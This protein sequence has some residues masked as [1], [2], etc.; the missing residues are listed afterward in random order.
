[1]IKLI[2]LLNEINGYN[3]QR[4]YRGNDLMMYSQA[5]IERTFPKLTIANLNAL[6]QKMIRSIKFYQKH[7]HDKRYPN[8]SD[9]FDVPGLTKS[10]IKIDRELARRKKYISKPI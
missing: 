3:Q 10:I 8:I 6:K 1:M 9:T 4:L 5:N 2:D 7:K